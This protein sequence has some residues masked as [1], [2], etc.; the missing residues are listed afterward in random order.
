[1]KRLLILAALLSLI[2]FAS[3]KVE[4]RKSPTSVAIVGSNWTITYATGS[5]L[6]PQLLELSPERAYFT[7]G[8]WVRLIDT[9]RGVVLGR[10]HVGAPVVAMKP[11]GEEQAEVEVADRSFRCRPYA[12]PGGCPEL[13]DSILVGPGVRVPLW[14]T[15]AMY[16]RG[17]GARE[18][19][20]QLPPFA[21][22]MT[23][24]KPERARQLLPLAEE[25]VTRDSYL[26][27]ARVTYAHLLSE[28]GD[29]RSGAAFENVLRS[30][31]GDFTEWL[32]IA[33]Y[34]Y[35]H[36][37][38][39]QARAA[40]DRGYKDFLQR[41]F[42]PRLF[43]PLWFR[44]SL[45]APNPSPRARLVDLPPEQMERIYRL[46]P[47]SDLSWV[48]WREY[49][50]VV[51]NQGH[52]ADAK[53]WRARAA[54]ARQNAP[55]LQTTFSLGLDRWFLT[56]LAALAAMAAYVAVVSLRYTAQRSADIEAG[57]R[58][59]AVPLISNLRYWTRTQR[60][61]LLFIV[62]IGWL[63][64]GLAGLYAAAFTRH[65][66]APAAVRNGNYVGQ[67]ARWHFQRLRASPER[68]LLLA[69]AYQ[70]GGD[71]RRAEETYRK[72]PQFAESWNNLGVLMKRRGQDDDARQAF[73]RALQIHPQLH[74][75][76]FNLDGSTPDFWTQLHREYLPDKP[77]LA[78]ARAPQLRA[79]YLGG[80]AVSLYLW[81]ALRGPFWPADAYWVTSY[82]GAAG[83]RET[84]VRWVAQGFGM[85]ALL[86]A[87]VMLRMRRHPATEVANRRYWIWELI[88]PGTASAWNVAGGMVLTAY[89]GCWLA[90]LLAMLWHSPTIWTAGTVW[91]LDWYRGE[92]T[93]AVSIGP[94]WH[95]FVATA[96]VLFVAN[97]LLVIKTRDAAPRSTTAAVAQSN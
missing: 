5:D 82:I 8:G 27:W 77:M 76:A 53:L 3:A 94:G 70:Q 32:P 78:L 92:G 45:F 10:W 66:F 81:S 85:A 11:A 40:Y 62:V 22:A 73:R 84:S 71:Y 47:Y 15:E 41:G 80:T 38:D 7:Q 67:N 13:H 23:R 33:A 43:V 95:W 64:M 35:A 12:A 93:T 50:E 86:F 6:A 87:V 54:D 2:P 88:F 42:D 74:E 36:H 69:I 72:L 16:W 4:L 19:L 25:L 68:D 39:E 24:V 91:M 46:S 57:R 20:G 58:K 17:V 83:V 90:L 49:A 31:G 30:P 79:A 9:T 26:P 37:Q 52:D 14:Q 51:Q 59:W 28:A 55:A 65:N 89:V 18:A 34:L 60:L 44:L 21:F 29:P 97:V 63:A 1:M 48:T 75:A 96:G 56:A 61:A